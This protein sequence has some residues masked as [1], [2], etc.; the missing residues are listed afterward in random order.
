MTDDR[1][2][3][4]IERYPLRPIPLNECVCGHGEED[5]ILGLTILSTISKCEICICSHFSSLAKI[6]ES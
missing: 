1:S 4:Q 2:T 5:H 6:S 3:K